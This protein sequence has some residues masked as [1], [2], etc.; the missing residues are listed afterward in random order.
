MM[1]VPGRTGYSC[2]KLQV[3]AVVGGRTGPYLKLAA[4]ESDYRMVV[5]MGKT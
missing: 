5:I 3:V 2:L 4:N 1:V